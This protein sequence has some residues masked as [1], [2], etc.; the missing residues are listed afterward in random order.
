MGHDN[1]NWASLFALVVVGGM[2][3][4]AIGLATSYRSSMPPEDRQVWQEQHVGMASGLPTVVCELTEE[5][6]GSTHPS[7]GV[8]KS[9]GTFPAST[10]R[11]LQQT[12]L[13]PH[14]LSPSGPPLYRIAPSHSPP[15]GQPTERL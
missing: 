7:A 13:R 4:G 11:V 14:P 6:A 5:D 1:Q 9:D 12:G 10:P 3:F 2:L 15:H 8:A